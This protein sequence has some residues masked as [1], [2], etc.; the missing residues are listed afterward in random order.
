MESALRIPSQVA[1]CGLYFHSLIEALPKAPRFEAQVKSTAVIDEFDRFKGWAGNIA[2]HRKGR[3][4]LEYRLRDAP[5]L[6]EETCDLLTALH[7]YLQDALDI[8]NGKRIPLDESAESDSESETD[9]EDRS[10]SGDTEL[11]LLLGSIEN[12]IT[13]LFRL[14]ISIRDPAPES[15]FRSMITVDKSHFHKHDIQHVEEKFKSAKEYLVNRLGIAISGRRSYLTYREEH[16]Q[17]LS[18]R[19][20]VIGIEE[21]RTEHTTNST[22]ATPMPA[23]SHAANRDAIDEGEDIQS[24]TSYAKTD[25]NTTLRVP[26]L[27]KEARDREYFEC[28]LCFMIVSIHTYPVWKQHVYRDLHP[29]CCTFEECTT[30]ERLYDSRHAW[31]KHELEAHRAI[32]QCIEGCEETFDTEDNFVGHV[33]KRHSELASDSI[34][35]VLK[36]TAV[37]SATLATNSRCPLC[38]KAMSLRMLQK[39]LGNHQEEL[40]LFAL[41]SNIDGMEDEDAESDVSEKYD[42]LSDTSEEEELDDG[43]EPKQDE[44]LKSP[45][46]PEE[47]TEETSTIKCICGISEDDG[48]TVL[49]E[50][51]DTWQHIGCYYEHASK[52]PDVHECADCNPRPINWKAQASATVLHKRLEEDHAGPPNSPLVSP[53][54]VVDSTIEPMSKSPVDVDS[55][56]SERKRFY[57]SYEAG[58]EEEWRNNLAKSA[59]LSASKQRDEDIPTEL[60]KQTFAQEDSEKHLLTFTASGPAPDSNLSYGINEDSNVEDEEEPRYCFCNELSYGNMIACDNPNCPREWF[61]LGCLN[62]E[63]PPSSKTEWFCCEECKDA[64]MKRSK[65][66]DKRLGSDSENMMPE[67]VPELAKA[68]Y[69]VNEKPEDLEALYQQFKKVNPSPEMDTK[70]LEEVKARY[71]QLKGGSLQEQDSSNPP[72]V[73]QIPLQMPIDDG[74]GDLESTRPAGDFSLYDTDPNPVHN[75]HRSK[76]SPEGTE[77]D[78]Q[79][80]ARSTVGPT[81]FHSSMSSE[82]QQVMLDRKRQ[83]LGGT[84][85]KI[86]TPQEINLT[87]E[88][89]RIINDSPTIQREQRAAMMARQYVAT[90]GIPQGQNPQ[91]YE[92]RLEQRFLQQMKVHDAAAAQPQ[93]KTFGRGNQANSSNEVSNNDFT[94]TRTE[95]LEERIGSHRRHRLSSRADAAPEIVVRDN[96]NPDRETD[97]L[98]FKHGLAKYHTHFPAQS[99]RDGSLKMSIVRHAAAKQLSVDDPR[100]IHMYFKGRKLKFDDRSAK[101]EGLRGDGAG[102]EIL[103]I[104]VPEARVL[105]AEDLD[106]GTSDR[107]YDRGDEGNDT[108]SDPIS[109]AAGKKKP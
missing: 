12:T 58:N 57:R 109:P 53:D 16:H 74:F 31:F 107:D 90:Q 68:P 27:P 70:F 26:R 13:C 106:S 2:A 47:E 41:P 62:M 5:H 77:F 81:G 102:S 92:S 34:I 1:N 96:E 48:S 103:C 9:E 54:S 104:V 66:K 69:E 83:Q 45:P 98:V 105:G 61:H 91:T 78:A 73:T 100:R 42:G 65:A 35:S 21:P 99:I 37:K 67:T 79:L 56:Q 8:V 59:K 43:G 51:C 4:S 87:P 72:G 85:E 6:K 25:K 71:K 32:W 50:V 14:S 30:A 17:K 60:D 10:N 7:D 108:T 76:I 20:E 39:H 40:A 18:K 23:I 38:D 75:T 52:V 82:Q 49:C 101:D 3:R 19:I 89:M 36:R 28:P 64:H 95:D 97:I 15:Q 93:Q 11:E 84:P 46:F 44:N 94:D 29:Y 88:Q 33:S 24:Q 22:E 55:S 80:E 86:Q 63:K